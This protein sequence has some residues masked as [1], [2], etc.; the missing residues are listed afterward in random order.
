[1]QYCYYS[2]DNSD[3]SGTPS[4]GNYSIN[5]PFKI[6][7]GD[8]TLTRSVNINGQKTLKVLNALNYWVDTLG[9]NQNMRHWKQD[10][11]P[12]SIARLRGS[13]PAHIYLTIPRA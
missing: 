3:V 9:A 1:M 2:N 4:V 12:A 8:Y 10:M 13:F 7:N 5:V 6:T 11:S